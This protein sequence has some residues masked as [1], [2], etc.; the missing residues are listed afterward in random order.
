MPKSCRCDGE[1]SRWRVS[2]AVNANLAATE[3]SQSAR[4]VNVG[5]CLWNTAST[6]S[7]TRVRLAMMNISKPSMKGFVNWSVT[8]WST[9]SRSPL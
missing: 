3:G 7:R 2:L 8:V 1:R 9:E 4:L 6:P 5:R